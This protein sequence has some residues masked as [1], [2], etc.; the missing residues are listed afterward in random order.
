[1]MR[2]SPEPSA[3]PA[4]AS[5][6]V[7]IVKGACPHDCPDT[8]ALDVHVKDGVALKVTG[9]AEHA[10]DRRRA[11]HQG[12]A[13][14]RAH[15][16]PRSLAASAA[17]RRAQRAK[18]ASSASAGRRRSR[19][20]AGR[21]VRAGGARIPQQILP[22]SYAGTMGLVQGESM[23]QRFF[24]RLGASL[25]DRTIC[26]SAGTAGHEITLGSRIGIDMELAD[27]A[28]LIIFWGC[29][30]D[31]LE[32]A[33]LGARPGSQAPRRDAHRHRSVPLADRRK[34]PQAHRAAA[35]HRCRAGARADA[36]ADS[37]RS[38]RPRLR[39]PPHA[40]IRGACASAC[41]LYDPERVAAICGIAPL[42]I[43]SL[44]H[45][46]GTTRPALIRANYGMQ[47]VRGGGMAMRNIACLPALVGAFRDAAGGMLLSTSRQ[48]HDR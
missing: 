41:A 6:A 38:D 27:E 47:R 17:P 16:S 19:P 25:L 3:A 33:F 29:N 26:A 42:K 5:A 46:Y 45:A 13:L 18:G 34:M 39:Q 48:F 21:L 2:G 28:K 31:H 37:R 22:Y 11:V 4:T 1:M 30:A 9:S 15:L 10:P 32:R 43:E 12:R 8:C 24:H 44:A 35:G 20:I 7:T 40:G 36:R 23:S 14:H